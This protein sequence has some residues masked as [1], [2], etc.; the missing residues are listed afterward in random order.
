[1][2]RAVATPEPTRHLRPNEKPR[3]LES[4]RNVPLHLA[5]KLRR[6]RLRSRL[7]RRKRVRPETVVANQAPAPRIRC[8]QTQADHRTRRRQMRR[9]NV[10]S[11][12]IVTTAMIGMIEA[13]VRIAATEMNATI[14]R[15]A[16]AAATPTFKIEETGDV[17]VAGA[18][19]DL[20]AT[21]RIR[22]N[23]NSHSSQYRLSPRVKRAAGT[24]PRAM[25]ASCAG[26]ATAISPTPVTH[27]FRRI[28]LGS[29]RF[30]VLIS[31]MRRLASIRAAAPRS[32]KSARSTKPIP[33]S[34]L[35]VLI[36][37]RF[38]HRIRSESCLWKRV[39]LRKAVRS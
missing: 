28:S 1:M 5:P 13:S 16:A 3:R 30:A 37:I 6:H 24:I 36:S 4:R 15:A 19:A 9:A 26:P 29:I 21:T 10:T 27:T 25:P 7:H 23:H 32:S 12:M 8:E 14:A 20:V 31:S 38:P 11:E 39:G 17:T 22:I 18:D 35:S 33:R 34:R 2:A